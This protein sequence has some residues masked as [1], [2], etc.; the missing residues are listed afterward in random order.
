MSQK[1]QY[2]PLKGPIRSVEAPLAPSDIRLLCGHGVAALTH[3]ASAIA[4]AIL[5]TAFTPNI[6]YRDSLND[7]RLFTLD[8]RWLLFAF[9]MLAAIEHTFYAFTP[10]A[11]I[12]DVRIG[13]KYP[14]PMLMRWLEYAISVPCMHVCIAVLCGIDDIIV[15]YAIAT[16]TMLC[17]SIGYWVEKEPNEWIYQG[18]AWATFL[19]VWVII[20][21]AY[22]NQAKLA[23]DFV[24]ALMVDIFLLEFAFGLVPILTKNNPFNR[25]W[26]Y[27]TLSFVA[28]QGLLWQV[29]GGLQRS[30]P[31]GS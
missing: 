29:Y 20:V 26:A 14:T 30:A 25:E 8:T 16:T 6:V 27:L 11:Y 22:S 12:G 15:L 23:P 24:H 3:T 4:I 1:Q 17:M 5:G 7:N 10:T 31:P 9:S 13:A 18:I 2:T 21:V 19:N 28:K